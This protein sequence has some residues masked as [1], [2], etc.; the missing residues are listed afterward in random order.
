[1]LFGVRHLKYHQKDKIP[2]FNKVL[3][4]LGQK[5]HDLKGLLCEILVGKGAKI[6]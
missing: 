1:M 3:G 2:P 4:E 6:G 5:K